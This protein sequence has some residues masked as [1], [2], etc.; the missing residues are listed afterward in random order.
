MLFGFAIY[1]EINVRVCF[2]MSE[3]WSPIGTFV[4]PGRSTRVKFRTWGEKIFRLIGCR[5]IPL[6]FPAI[7]AV[8]FSISCLT[9]AKSSN[10]RPGRW[11]NSAHSPWAATPAGGRGA[12][13]ASGLASRSPGIFISCRINGRLVTIPLPLGKKSRPTIFSSTDDLPEDWEPTTTY[14]SKLVKICWNQQYY[15]QLVPFRYILRQSKRTYD[16]RQ[17]EGVIADGVENKILK[18]VDSDKQIISEWGHCTEEL[19]S[20]ANAL[21]L[22]LSAWRTQATASIPS[23]GLRGLLG[24]SSWE[25]KR[26]VGSKDWQ[27]CSRRNSLFTS[28]MDHGAEVSA[29]APVTFSDSDLVY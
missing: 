23:E 18:L 20:S 16:L 15:M 27:Y 9:R 1:S 21:Q 19:K 4:K 3:G 24:L 12:G 29:T 25:K 7:L 8:S 10:L 28:E 5:L 14:T 13:S 22:E 2:S 26:P 17:V 11:W 6:L